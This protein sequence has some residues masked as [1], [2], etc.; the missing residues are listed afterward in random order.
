MPSRLA[1]VSALSLLLMG[2]TAA[3]A[4]ALQTDPVQ[5]HIGH[6]MTGFGGTPDGGGLLPTAMAEAE[7]GR[8]YVQR[9]LQDTSNLE[10][11][12][13]Q[14]EGVIHAVDP[15]RIEEGPGLGFGVKAAAQGIVQHIELAASSDGAS[16][17]VQ[18]HATHVSAAASAVAARAEELVALAEEVLDASDYSTAEGL[19]T[20]MRRLADQLVEGEDVDENGEISFDEGEGGLMHVQRHMELMTAGEDME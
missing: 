17:N 14:A 6:V 2:V 16:E 10:W 9:G 3:P 4:S 13:S 11:M 15:S 8:E 5:T 20:R 12:Q 19:V 1:A 18:T 7:T